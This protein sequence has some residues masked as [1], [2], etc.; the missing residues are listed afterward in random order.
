MTQLLLRLAVVPASVEESKWLEDFT[1]ELLSAAKYSR[2]TAV[3]H[4]LVQLGV[5][6]PG[7]CSCS[8]REQGDWL[9]RNH[10]AYNRT[11]RD[12]ID[13]VPRARAGIRKALYRD[14]HG[15]VSEDGV[16]G[17]IAHREAGSFLGDFLRE[18]PTYEWFA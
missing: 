11:V 14:L 8:P 1:A 17:K 13:S 12:A 6:R 16:Y 3:L 9:H 4:Q 7:F 5:E 15:P 10:G 2:W 18:K